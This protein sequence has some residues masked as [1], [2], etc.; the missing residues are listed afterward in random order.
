M[1]PYISWSFLHF[2]HRYTVTPPERGHMSCASA[3][4]AYLPNFCDIVVILDCDMF[5]VQAYVQNV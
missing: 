3:Y 4:I 2:S 5:S 1:G